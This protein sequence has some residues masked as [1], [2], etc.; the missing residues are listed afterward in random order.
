MTDEEA[1]KRK[2]ILRSW[3]YFALVG[4]FALVVV[5]LFPDR[6]EAVVTTMWSYLV[7]LAL[8]LP[9]VMILLGLFNEWV[10]DEMVVEYLGE[11]SGITGIG[12]AIVLGSTPT[13]PL[14]V[15]FPIAAELLEKE[16]SVANVVVFLTA[17]ACLKL[18][19]E[20]IELQFLGWRFMTLRLVLTAVVAVGMGLVVE[21]LLPNDVPGD[22]DMTD[23]G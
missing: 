21:T 7:E 19:Q 14:Y 4:G 1:S 9:A 11:R 2:K 6:Q 12:T 15:A 8:I 22:T 3:G 18:P 16:A 13:G 10:P 17:W 20:L 5:W 23:S